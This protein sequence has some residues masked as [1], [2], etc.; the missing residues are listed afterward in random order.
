MKSIL[1]RSS[2]EVDSANI[3][4]VNVLSL[5]EAGLESVSQPIPPPPYLSYPPYMYPYSHVQMPVPPPPVTKPKIKKGTETKI[6]K[7][8]KEDKILIDSVADTIQSEAE[9]S[10]RTAVVEENWEEKHKLLL[11]EF[12]RQE[13]E[14]KFNLSGQ[15]E[16]I[17]QSFL[18]SNKCRMEKTGKRFG[19]RTDPPPPPL[20][21]SVANHPVLTVI[22]LTFLFV[23]YSFADLPW[24]S[25]LILAI[26]GYYIHSL[27]G[28]VLSFDYH[29]LLR[30]PPLNGSRLRTGC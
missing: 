27:C 9:Q 28:P 29:L 12:I 8:I 6:E 19:K 1:K 18:T 25:Y 4:D 7:E 17:F 21:V 16:Q 2:S 14:S 26:L 30:T 3:I 22:F 5:K 13:Q 20:R 10:Y 15:E 11:D 23:L 24:G